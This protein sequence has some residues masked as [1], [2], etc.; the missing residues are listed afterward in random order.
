MLI[1]WVILKMK[2]VHWNK[3]NLLYQNNKPKV[4][5][6]KMKFKNNSYSYNCYNYKRKNKCFKNNNYKINYKNKRHNIAI[7][8]KPHPSY[9]VNTI[10]KCFKREINLNN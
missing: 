2:L 1:I 9:K 6:N 5:Y 3:I 10:L 8:N 4:K 7:N